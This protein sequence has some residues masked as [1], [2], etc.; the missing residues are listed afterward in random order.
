MKPGNMSAA[1][2]QLRVNG[3]DGLRVADGSIMR[4]SL[5]LDPLREGR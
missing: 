5:A 2:A 1:E 4:A 3:S